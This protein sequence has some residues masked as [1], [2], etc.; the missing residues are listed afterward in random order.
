LQQDIAKLSKDEIFRN[1][2]I[3]EENFQSTLNLTYMLGLKKYK[4][5]IYFRE[6]LEYIVE[7]IYINYATINLN[8]MNSS[9]G[10]ITEDILQRALRIC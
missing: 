10:K 4:D 6:H 7:E 3:Q 5:D 9:R 2:N 8:L 1:L